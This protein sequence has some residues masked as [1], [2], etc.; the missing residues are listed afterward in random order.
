MLF[1]SGSL[2]FNAYLN[3]VQEQDST[4]RPDAVVDAHAATLAAASK[5][6]TEPHTV[7]L[8]SSGTY[9]FESWKG[10]APQTLW[11]GG[12]PP[13]KPLRGVEGA[14]ASQPGGSGGGRETSRERETLLNTSQ[15][16]ATFVHEPHIEQTTIKKQATTRNW[17][18]RTL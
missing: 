9:G 5:A 17:L 15:R 18:P 12:L 1:N 10:P 3:V 16:T 8:Q 13:P 6:A 7:Q 2:L 11:V 4:D 14:A